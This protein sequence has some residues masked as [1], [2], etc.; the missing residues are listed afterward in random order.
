MLSPQAVVIGTLDRV[1]VLISPQTPDPR[2]Q[3]VVI[4]T[5]GTRSADSFEF[6]LTD[7]GNLIVLASG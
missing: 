1:P 4:G 6:C 3:T 5:L 2:P 7:G